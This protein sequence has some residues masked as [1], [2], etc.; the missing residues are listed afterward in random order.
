MATRPKKTF[1]QQAIA[2]AIEGVR[3]GE[4]GPFGAV[5][6]RGGE[7]LATACNRV[8]SR[9]DP[10]AHAEVEAIRAA[11]AKLGSH[12]LD[13]CEIYASCEPCPMC[14][15]A[16]FWARVDRVFYACDRADA[17]RAGFDDSK[18]HVEVEKMLAERSPPLVPFLREEGLAVFRD[19]LEKGDRIPY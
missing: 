12:R 18:L 6:V 7:V 15:A 17:A 9:K 3:S 4:G 13:G 8:T 2:A 10:T 11:C 5:V 19:W 14:F 16:A 1:M